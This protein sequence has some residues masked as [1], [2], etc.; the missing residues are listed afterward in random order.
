MNKLSKENVNETT[1][2]FFI[3]KNPLSYNLLL[4]LFFIKLLL[5]LLL[6]LVKA[7]SFSMVGRNYLLV[8]D[9]VAWV[10]VDSREIPR[11]WPSLAVLVIG[12]TCKS[13]SPQ[14]VSDRT[15]LL[16]A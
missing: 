14:P 15:A 2:Q 10:G 7:A 9:D 1:L 3:R 6:L 4:L 12:T 8:V 5:L 13:R 16:H 11:C